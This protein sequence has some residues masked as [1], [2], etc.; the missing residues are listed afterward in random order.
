MRKQLITLF[1]ITACIL[2]ACGNKEANSTTEAAADAV[3]E[4]TNE[5]TSETQAAI[6]N[7]WTESSK[8]AMP[9]TLGYGI[10]APEGST[11]VSYQV[12]KESGMGQVKFTYGD[13]SQDYTYR[14]K[15]ASEF[16]DISGL[17]YTWEYE[18]KITIGWCEGTIKQA[19][20]GDKTVQVC[21][22]YDV[23]PGIMYSLSTSAAD[24]DGFDLT[25]IAGLVYYP[26]QGEVEEPFMP[27]NFLET[28]LQRDTFDS[29]DEIISLLEK[30]NA[31]A[32]TK[33]YGYDDDVLLIAEGAY[34]N[35]DGNMASIEGSVYINDNG[36]VKNVGNIYSM[37]TAYPI[38]LDADN[39]VYCG[40]NHEINVI[41]LSKEFNSVMN[42]TYAYE[43]FDEKGNASYGGFIRSTNSVYEDGENIDEKDSSKLEGLYKNY[44]ETTPIN[45]TVI[46]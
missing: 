5:T 21:L 2:C 11:N 36:T 41:A 30:G 8:E 19:K 22:W 23:A 33:I 40:G 29:F 26:M 6:A 20:D 39:K 45:Y 18:D 16:E 42:M 27:A 34:D 14:I 9:E 31:Y 1:A 25:A 46:E 43:S 4:A 35:L 28:K 3:T 32:I 10:D 24:L 7:P 37:G 15:S 38:S 17:N 13:P 12:N 44:S